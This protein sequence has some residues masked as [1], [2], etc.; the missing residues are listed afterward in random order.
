MLVRLGILG[1]LS[2]VQ[3]KAPVEGGRGILLQMLT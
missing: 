1:L 2:V 3:T